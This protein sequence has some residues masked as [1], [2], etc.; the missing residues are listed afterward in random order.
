MD[1]LPQKNPSYNCE[2]CGFITRN[3]KDWRRHCMT[4]KHKMETQETHLETEK[5]HHC[6]C[7]GKYKTRAGLWKHANKCSF[8]SSSSS[9]SSSSLVVYKNENT[10]ENTIQMK[11]DIT[12]NAELTAHILKLYQE[13][14]EIMKKYQEMMQEMMDRPTATQIINNNNNGNNNNITNNQFN[15][16]FYLNETCKNAINIKEFIES[17][18]IGI[19]DI[20]DIGERG[21]VKCYG[22]LFV[23][24]LIKLPQIERP[25][26]TVD[27]K[28]GVYMIKNENNEWERDDNR[29]VLN[30]YTN[31]FGNIC[32]SSYLDFNKNTPSW[33]NLQSKEHDKSVYSAINI[34]ESVCGDNTEKKNGSIQLRVMKSTMVDKSK[35]YHQH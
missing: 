18:P 29:V 15:L 10:H 16:H 31:R 7:G 23:K 9:S 26:Q 24:N 14:Q 27:L 35:R 6:L 8:S 30:K 3:K 1:K 4:A 2:S 17:I 12:Q 5:T 22:D 19:Q 20:I 11:N 28:R 32:Y 25:I 34:L 13:N 21:Y 33:R